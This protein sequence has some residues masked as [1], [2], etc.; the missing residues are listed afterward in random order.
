MRRECYFDIFKQTVEAL[1]P[2]LKK[3]ILGK[4]IYWDDELF[5][6]YELVSC[7]RPIEFP[8]PFFSDAIHVT[9]EWTF[10]LSEIVSFKTFSEREKRPFESEPV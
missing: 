5:S 8:P 2:Q 9:N 3:E 1:C 4:A 6:W 10:F 7:T